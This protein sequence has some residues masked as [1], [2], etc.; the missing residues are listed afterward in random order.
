[1]HRDVVT[2]LA[3]VAD[4]RGGG[5]LLVTGRLV[6]KST[7]PI[8]NACVPS[9]SIP[10]INLHA[11]SADTTIRVWGLGPGARG[12]QRLRRSSIRR[13]S[14]Q[15]LPS[16]PVRTL[17]GHLGAV[18]CLAADA[19]LDVVVSGGVDGWCIIHRLSQGDLLRAIAP[20]N[21]GTGAVRGLTLTKDGDAV[22]IQSKSR[23]LRAVDINGNASGFS[24]QQGEGEICV[25]AHSNDREVLFSAGAAGTIV[26]RSVRT[27]LAGGTLPVKTLDRDGITVANQYAVQSMALSFCGNFLFAGLADG[28]ID[29]VFSS[30][31]HGQV[32]ASI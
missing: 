21:A 26:V 30:C 20:G 25:L 32:L 29:A 13:W 22:W 14:Q 18:S 2:C 4:T 17:H 7:N 28:S 3:V 12:R 23:Q 16:R 19:D 1:M 24:E 6:L 31:S 27:L 9:C 15:P 5:K 11:G 10:Y 8:C